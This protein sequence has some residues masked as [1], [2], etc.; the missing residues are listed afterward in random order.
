MATSET[1]PAVRGVSALQKE[2]LKTK[3]HLN[4]VDEN[5][6]K[7]TGRE[8]GDLRWYIICILLLT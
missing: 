7:L 6:K 1:A 4:D 5:I 2:L 3:E 8:P